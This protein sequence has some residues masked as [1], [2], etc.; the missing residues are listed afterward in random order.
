M[1]KMYQKTVLAVVVTAL[2]SACSADTKCGSSSSNDL[3]ID[4]VRENE[5]L[6]KG[7]QMLLAVKAREAEN[8]VR[9]SYKIKLDQ[10]SEGYNLTKNQLAEASNACKS[11]LAN[12]DVLA[13]KSVLIQTTAA[14]ISKLEAFQP[15][16]PARFYWGANSTQAQ[17]DAWQ[18]AQKK[19]EGQ[20]SDRNAKLNQLYSQHAAYSED[21]NQSNVYF[22]SVCEFV[23][24]SES[25]LTPE[26]SNEIQSNMEYKVSPDVAQAA[27]QY[28]TANMSPIVAKAQSFSNQIANIGKSIELDAEKAATK[29]VEEWKGKIENAEYSIDNIIVKSRDEKT[30]ESICE[31]DIK[32][33]VDEEIQQS[34]RFKYS[35]EKTADNKLYAT[36]I[37]QQ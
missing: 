20:V 7:W 28:I 5:L 27:Q 37:S 12:S 29:A 18:A 17:H 21:L 16:A 36:I 2:L 4:L 8:K 19:Y 15:T 32:V 24:N 25:N 35:L 30:G 3:V 13:K 14:E 22:A 1:A 26:N 11:A 34:S 23:A 6:I 9:E 31:A 33:V 10:A